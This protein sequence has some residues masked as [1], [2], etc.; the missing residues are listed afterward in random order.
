MGLTKHTL[1]AR[2]LGQVLEN[3][4]DRFLVKINAI[5]QDTPIEKL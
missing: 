3:E 4:S 2:K 1:S 5:K